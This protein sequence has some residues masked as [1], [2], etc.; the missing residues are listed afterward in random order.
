MNQHNKE[1][2]E[3]RVNLDFPLRK[4]GDKTQ[5]LYDLSIWISN[6]IKEEIDPKTILNGIL[7]RETLGTT[8]FGDG[9]AIPHGK[10]KDLKQPVL[11][12]VALEEPIEWD[13]LD[14]QKVEQLFVILVPEKDTDNTHLG[15]LSTLA[16]HLMDGE[17]KRQIK[18]IQSESELIKYVRDIFK[19][20]R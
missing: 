3:I 9:F 16:Y 12:I 10:I 13:A 7:E 19:E 11:V 18:S 1:E 15:L 20:G 4:N 6:Q 8:G 5:L 17:T 2:L 14:D